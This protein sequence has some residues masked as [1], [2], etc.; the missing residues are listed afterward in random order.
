MRKLVGGASRRRLPS[1]RRF[2]RAWRRNAPGY[3]FLI[4]W[5]IGFFG[6]TLGPT[7]ASLYLSFTDYDLLTPAALGRAEELRIRLLS[8]QAARQRA[9]GHVALRRLVDPAE[10]DG[11]AGACH[12]ARSR[13]SRRRRLPRHLLS[14]VAARGVGRHRDPV[15]ADFRHRRPDQSAAAPDAWHQSDPAGSRTPIMRC[16]RWSC[17]RSGSS[18]RP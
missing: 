2:A 4:P 16:R 9:L 7:I 17:W 14:A 18:V 6:L 10:T 11:R 13:H 8:G 15:A 3:L 12:G 1:P 5:L